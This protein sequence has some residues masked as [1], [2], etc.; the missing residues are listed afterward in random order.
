[1]KT[2]PPGAEKPDAMPQMPRSEGAAGHGVSDPTTRTVTGSHTVETIE[3]I[4]ARATSVTIVLQKIMEFETGYPH[5][6]LND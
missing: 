6:G 3:T 1:M 5:G 2:K 4:N